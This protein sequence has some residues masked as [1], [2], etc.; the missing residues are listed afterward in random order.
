M[1]PGAMPS[2]ELLQQRPGFL[3]VYGVQPLAEPGIDLWQELAGGIA[4]SLLL[5]EATQAHGGSQFQGLRLLLASSLKGLT[6][7]RF[8]CLL[9]LPLSACRL[10]KQFALETIQL[11]LPT[12]LCGCCH[13]GKGLGKDTE[14]L[15][16]LPDCSIPLSEQSE[17]VWSGPFRA[18]AL[19]RGETLAHLLNT[20]FALPLHR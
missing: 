1:R 4:L 19:Q 17:I 9:C 5:P 14:S 20:R 6:E 10:Q 15:V 13:C 7:I 16:R 18:R 12:S 2:R 11:C 3:E 8:W